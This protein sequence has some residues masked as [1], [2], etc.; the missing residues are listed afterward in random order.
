MNDKTRYIPPKNTPLDLLQSYEDAPCTASDVPRAVQTAM[1]ALR[2]YKW[3]Q[4]Q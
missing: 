3:A 4:R 2:G 1:D